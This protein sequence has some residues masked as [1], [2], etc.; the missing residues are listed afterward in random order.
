MGGVHSSSFKNIV[1]GESVGVR[2]GENDKDDFGELVG[3]V[4][5]ISVDFWH[6]RPAALYQLS[7]RDGNSQEVINNI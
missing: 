7:S 2:P 5:L 4:C 6:Y 1:Q 3:L